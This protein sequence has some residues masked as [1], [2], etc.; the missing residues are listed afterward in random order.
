MK[1]E[2]ANG[3]D[4]FLR[5][6]FLR[7]KMFGAQLVR[8]S[9]DKELKPEHRSCSNNRTILLETASPHNT[10]THTYI[11]TVKMLK[12]RHNKC[13]WLIKILHISTNS[14]PQEAV[15]QNLKYENGQVKSL[16]CPFGLPEH[17]FTRG[18]NKVQ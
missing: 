11:H 17:L 3:T 14:L 1:V 4:L 13:K 16:I 15:M 2:T 8:P 18:K 5:Y 10:H 9:T 7:A 6:L 12:K